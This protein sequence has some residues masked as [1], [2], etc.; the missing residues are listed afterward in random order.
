MTSMRKFRSDFAESVDTPIKPLA[1]EKGPA[2]IGPSWRIG[3][4]SKGGQMRRPSSPLSEYLG[5]FVA[6]RRRGPR[7]RRRYGAVPEC[8]QSDFDLLLQPALRDR[9]R[10]I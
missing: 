3:G 1:H 9:R 10:A 6:L 7:Y 8:E 4:G 5:E 2:T